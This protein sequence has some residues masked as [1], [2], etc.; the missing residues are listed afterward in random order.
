MKVFDALLIPNLHWGPFSAGYPLKAFLR[1]LN[2]FLRNLRGLKNFTSLVFKG[3]DF[4]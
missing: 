4:F 2:L 3:P 1:G